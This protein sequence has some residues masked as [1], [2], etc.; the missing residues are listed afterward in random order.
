MLATRPTATIAAAVSVLVCGSLAFAGEPAATGEKRVE[1]A[2]V[3]AA[4]DAR[5]GTKVYDA[6]TNLFVQ[7]VFGEL[8]VPVNGLVS[9]L[10]RSG[11]AVEGAP[12]AGDLV[13]FPGFVAI[14][15]GA[16]N[17]VYPSGTSGRAQ[18]RTVIKRPLSGWY[19]SNMSG[20][21]S[22][23]DAS[24]TPPA[25]EEEPV[26][27]EPATDGSYGDPM[28][29]DDGQPDV[30]GGGDADQPLDDGGVDILPDVGDPGVDKPGD[31]S[32]VDAP[33]VSEDEALRRLQALIAQ[34]RAGL[35]PAELAELRE[36]LRGRFSTDQL[37][38]LQGIFQRGIDPSAVP[39]L[40]ERLL[41]LVRQPV[42]PSVV[43]VAE[44]IASDL[45]GAPG[46]DRPDEP[47]V[48]DPVD[49]SVVDESEL[50]PR[51]EAIRRLTNLLE[52]LQ[53]GL[54][55]EQLEAL[56]ARLA[57]LPPEQ[58]D[59]LLKRFQNGLGGSDVA[60]L[61]EKLL[62]RVRQPGADPSVLDIAEMIARDLVRD[63]PVAQRENGAAAALA[64]VLDVERD[65]VAGDDPV[66]VPQVEQQRREPDASSVPD[67]APSLPPAQRNPAQGQGDAA[68][69]ATRVAPAV[70]PAPPEKRYGG[71]TY[72]APDA[73]AATDAPADTD[74]LP[75]DEQVI[76]DMFRDLADELEAPEPAAPSADVPALVAPGTATSAPDAP[77][78]VATDADASRPSD[79]LPH[80]VDSD[81][82][83]AKILNLV[84][85]QAHDALAP[86]GALQRQVDARLRA[87]GI[88]PSTAVPL[89]DAYELIVPPEAWPDEIVPKT[90]LQESMSATAAFLADLHV[91]NGGQ[92]S[93]P[94]RRVELRKTGDIGEQLKLD[95]DSVTL[96]VGLSRNPVT[97][98]LRRSAVTQSRLDEQWKALESAEAQGD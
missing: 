20:V 4:L 50:L 66:V 42:A 57:E 38:E 71:Q 79:L 84:N 76:G 56:K 68:G 33:T 89:R 77:A 61:G 35:S 41:T 85:L 18:F 53:N 25:E 82:P 30:G 74:V 17:I 62:D 24:A 93:A 19:A 26:A 23:F 3:L 6:S 52:E 14:A 90:P 40:A 27:E 16:G 91:A 49:E 60:A 48:V 10:A 75:S 87:K 8:G 13:F 64:D 15:D 1:P 12:E 81:E 58:R 86:D 36:R 11:R 43:D 78:P 47:V 2:A 21:R 28:P 92:A 39:D 65:A 70:D 7:D 73:G 59:E 45:L 83:R 34:L 29:G 80:L 5:V 54:S 44:L 37:E 98:G 97:L 32:G 55:P 31:G 88:D 69:G 9:S 96:Q 95:E 51:N 67:V 46:Q 63:V 72:G 22:F 94:F